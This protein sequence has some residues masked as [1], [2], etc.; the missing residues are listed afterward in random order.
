MFLTLSAPD[1]SLIIWQ[2]AF[3]G[4]VPIAMNSMFQDNG[5][6]LSFPSTWGVALRSSPILCLFDALDLSQFWLILL[7]FGAEGPAIAAKRVARVRFQDA[8]NSDDEQS[9]TKLRGNFW[10]VN[11]LFI[12]GTL[13]SA[14]KLFACSGIAGTQL[15]AA[16]Y[17]LSWLVPQ[18]LVWAAESDWNTALLPEMEPGPLKRIAEDGL[19]SLL[20]CHILGI[21]F[22]TYWIDKF[23]ALIV[24]NQVIDA[25]GN[26]NILVIGAVSTLLVTV[27]HFI[28][29]N[30]GSDQKLSPSA[31]QILCLAILSAATIPIGNSWNALMQFIF[32]DEPLTVASTE[33]G[34]LGPQIMLE[35]PIA[36]FHPDVQHEL[37]G[38]MMAPQIIAI[39]ANVSF[40]QVMNAQWLSAAGSLWE[41][42]SAIFTILVDA[43]VPALDQQKGITR[44]FRVSYGYSFCRI[45]AVS[46][47][48]QMLWVS[49]STG[50]WNLGWMSA[51]ILALGTLLFY[52]N[53]MSL[54]FLNRIL[55]AE[56]DRY[57]PT[58]AGIAFVADTSILPL[59]WYAYVWPLE[60]KYS[61]TRKPGWTNVL[62]SGRKPDSSSP[63]I[64]E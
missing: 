49:I 34:L 11:I 46:Y 25:Q 16:F 13:L 14:I 18:G 8:L 64:H 1:D 57:S 56:I 45:I 22:H 36:A 31:W 9:L 60:E 32:N 33:F 54:F 58:T 51:A 24:D 38:L 50:S 3:W 29:Y 59:L 2:S 53:G 37:H 23:F 28:I 61:C 12:I 40:W 62:G 55:K 26:I 47:V 44:T 17:L 6:V 52:L 41:T 48:G 15:C 27:P 35:T 21:L 19:L 30:A 42:L 43:F 10:M 4:I 20:P 39:G 5:M 7:V 63:S